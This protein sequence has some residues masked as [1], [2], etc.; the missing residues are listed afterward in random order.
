MKLLIIL[1]LIAAGS[2]VYLF[3]P[4]ILEHVS[5]LMHFLTILVSGHHI[6][7]ELGHAIHNQK[8]TIHD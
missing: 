4:G 2:G 7:S 5:H 3:L 8:V 1:G 6:F